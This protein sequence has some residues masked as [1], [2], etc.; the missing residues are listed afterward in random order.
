MKAVSEK[1]KVVPGGLMGPFPEADIA[2]KAARDTA[3]LLLS[4][5][6][7]AK[8]AGEVGTLLPVQPKGPRYQSHLT[9]TKPRP[10]FKN[11][12]THQ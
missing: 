5:A 11:L 1:A 10:V 4:T 2:A 8:A 7:A 3:M 6:S 12:A 9:Q